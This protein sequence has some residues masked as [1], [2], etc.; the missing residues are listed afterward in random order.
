M[1]DITQQTLNADMQSMGVGRY[2]GKVESARKR[3]AEIETNYGQRLMRGVLPDFTK[4]IEDWKE[5]VAFYDRKARYQID[6][7]R[8]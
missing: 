2:R 5:K 3:D 7:I 8:I 6:K 1:G 4:G